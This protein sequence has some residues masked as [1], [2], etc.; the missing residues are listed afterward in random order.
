MQGIVVL[1]T[2]EAHKVLDVPSIQLAAAIIGGVG[3]GALLAAVSAGI[4]TLGEAGLQALAE[5]G[6]DYAN[7][8]ERMLRELPAV[9]SRL[10]IGRVFCVAIAAAFVA[11]SLLMAYGVGTA[12]AP[13]INVPA[14]KNAIIAMRFMF[15]L[16]IILSLLRSCFLEL[17]YSIG[18]SF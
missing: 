16:L 11:Y 2:L 6:G 3:L 18:P 14:A 17:E 8:A 4:H 7:V 10:L 5:E 12:T 15:V 9:Q 1:G 13:A